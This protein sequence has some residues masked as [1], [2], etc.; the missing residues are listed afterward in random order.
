M[1]ALRMIMITLYM[2]LKS[3]KEHESAKMKVQSK[4]QLQREIYLATP[5]DGAT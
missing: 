4:H 2:T 1:L 3:T 5:D